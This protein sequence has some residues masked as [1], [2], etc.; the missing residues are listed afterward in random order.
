MIELDGA[1]S[2]AL[3]VVFDGS[4]DQRHRLDQLAAVVR[5]AQALSVY[6][7]KLAGKLIFFLYDGFPFPRFGCCRTHVFAVGA[8]KC[9][10]ASLS[11]PQQEDGGGDWPQEFDAQV[12]SRIAAGELFFLTPSLDAHV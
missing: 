4:F 10:R 8:R 3:P 1:W 9:Y 7:V 11:V 5:A 2:D 12:R 6:A